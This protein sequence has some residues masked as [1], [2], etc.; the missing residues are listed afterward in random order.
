MKICFSDIR[1]QLE[2]F[3]KEIHTIENNTPVPVKVDKYT[4][5]QNNYVLLDRGMEMIL[6]K[7]L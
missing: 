5:L 2:L 4:R 6:R 3:S 1:N 7:F